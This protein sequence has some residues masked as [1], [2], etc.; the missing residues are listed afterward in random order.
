MGLAAQ[1]V[2]DNIDKI[3]A[4]ADL[5]VIRGEGLHGSEMAELLQF[6][7]IQHVRHVV[8][9]VVYKILDERDSR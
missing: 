4:K 1:E 2:E 7:T 3:A 9:E 5:A 8:G 6:Y